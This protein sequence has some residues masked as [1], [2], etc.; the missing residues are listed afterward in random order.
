V[1]VAELIQDKA[2]PSLIAWWCP[3]CKGM[4]AAPLDRWHWNSSL[5]EPTLRPSVVHDG[6][7]KCHCWIRDGQVDFLGD[8]GHE[9]AGKTVPLGEVP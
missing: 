1:N 9:F 7:P 5:K 3:G 6:P 2:G 8:C 4:H